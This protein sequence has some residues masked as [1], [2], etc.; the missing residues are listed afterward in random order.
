MSDFM[1]RSSEIEKHGQ[2]LPHWQQ[3]GRMRFV[4][5]RLADALPATLLRGWKEARQNWLNHHP[6]PWD[7]EVEKEYH[8]KFTAV[9]ERWLDAGSGFCLFREAE[10][11]E[12]LEN[13]RMKFQD[14]TVVHESWLIN[15]DGDGDAEE[16]I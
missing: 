5:F 10:N 2:K 3:E 11:R 1:D 9:L 15:K 6:E 7:P 13:V 14:E 16:A 12:I 8:Q 4:T